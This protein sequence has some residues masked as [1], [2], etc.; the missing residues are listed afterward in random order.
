MAGVGVAGA[1]AEKHPHRTCNERVEACV[2]TFFLAVLFAVLA[3]VVALIS[4]TL[5]IVRAFKIDATQGVLCL[6]VP[7]YAVYFALAKMSQPSKALLAGG[8]LGGWALCAALGVVAVA[9]AERIK[10]EAAQTVDAARVVPNPL[11]PK[12]TASPP[13]PQLGPPAATADWNEIHIRR[14]RI[15]LRVPPGAQL[16]DSEFPGIFVE[17]ETDQQ[18]LLSL[19]M[20][21]RATPREA[22]AEVRRELRDNDAFR[23]FVHESDGAVVARVVHAAGAT[24]RR[25]CVA[26]ACT[27]V[28]GKLVCGQLGDVDAPPED[29]EAVPTDADCMQVVTMVRS[30]RSL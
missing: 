30:I 13:A 14:A 2:V 6:C 22:I 7:F 27:R 12:A 8:W 11:D 23:G 1:S 24:Q 28:R 20:E 3:G 4:W 19:D 16:D 17:T 15:A 26:F 10:R 5:V 18:V 9:S 21:E 29:D 25:S